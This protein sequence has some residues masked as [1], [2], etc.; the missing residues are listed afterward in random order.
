MHY[1]ISS[2]YRN[3][4]CERSRAHDQDRTCGWVNH[5]EVYLLKKDYEF[6]LVGKITGGVTGYLR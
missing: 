3:I 5:R 6:Y 2:F 1:I 4:G